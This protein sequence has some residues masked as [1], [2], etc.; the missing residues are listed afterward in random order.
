[1][2]GDRFGVEFGCFDDEY[3][4]MEVCCYRQRCVYEILLWCDSF[5]LVS[6]WSSVGVVIVAMFIGSVRRAFL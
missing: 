4:S 6:I 2:L 1:M 5:I 3:G